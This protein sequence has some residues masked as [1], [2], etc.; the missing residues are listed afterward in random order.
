MKFSPD[1]HPRSSAEWDQVRA[2]LLEETEWR[3]SYCDKPLSWS[4]SHI[5]HAA[6]RCRGGTDHFAN[7]HISCP[8]CNLVKGGRFVA[9]WLDPLGWSAGEY[10]GASA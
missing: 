2:A 6:P 3:C 4:R 7:L 10:A 8:R 1:F 9:E 5:D